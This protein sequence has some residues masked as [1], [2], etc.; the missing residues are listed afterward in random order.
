MTLRIIQWNTGI[1]GSAGVRAIQAH[2]ELELVGCHAWSPE[3]SGR[4]VGELCGTGPLGVEATS[5]VEALLALEPDCVLYTPQFPD[6][7]LMLRVLE[8]GINIVSTSYFIT[9]RSFGTRDATRLHEAPLGR[10]SRCLSAC[11]SLS[12]IISWNCGVLPLKMC[13]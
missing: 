7:E 12:G 8:A 3:K 6:V 9:G 13:H 4:D 1:V 10:R 11:C 5:D 2:P